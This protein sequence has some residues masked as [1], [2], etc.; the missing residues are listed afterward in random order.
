MADQDLYD[1][2]DYD[3][4]ADCYTYMTYPQWFAVYEKLYRSRS[5]RL[6]GAYFRKDEFYD[7]EDL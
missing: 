1:D 4:E 3:D 5:R 7:D 6:T 2:D